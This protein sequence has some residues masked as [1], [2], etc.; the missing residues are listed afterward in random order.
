MGKKLVS[1]TAKVLS[2]TKKSKE[3]EAVAIAYEHIPR[4]PEEQTHGSLYAV[5]ELEDKSGH[6]E[7]I[8]EGI[9]D[10]F[11]NEYYLDTDREPLASFESAL[12]KINEELAERSGEGQI[13]WLGKL[14]GV[15]AVLS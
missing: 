3:K 5:L 7:E 9:I 6:A 11:H 1:K 15:L 2:E 13:N 12:A 8:A 4:N 10:A 14:N